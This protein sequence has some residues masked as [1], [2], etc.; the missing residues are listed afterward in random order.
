MRE[1]RGY[2]DVEKCEKKIWRSYLATRVG[3]VYWIYQVSR[4]G[5]KKKKREEKEKEK[6]KP[7]R[8]N[9]WMNSRRRQKRGRGGWKIHERVFK[10]EKK[11]RCTTVLWRLIIAV[12][13]MRGSCARGRGANWKGLAGIVR[14]NGGG[15]TKNEGKGRER[16]VSGRGCENTAVVPTF[17]KYFLSRDFFNKPSPFF[18]FSFF[19]SFTSIASANMNIHVRIR[20]HMREHAF[21]LEGRKCS[22]DE[23]T[24]EFS[25]PTRPVV[26]PFP[27]PPTIILYT[28]RLISLKFSSRTIEIIAPIPTLC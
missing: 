23:N 15:K 24:F 22:S 3:T 16:K 9:E 10:E 1:Y 11:Y 21:R 8:R 6:E 27:F 13:K 20:E 14:R 4:A 25:H 2:H 28:T 7:W 5:E 17:P 12:I 26:F 18:F 19:F